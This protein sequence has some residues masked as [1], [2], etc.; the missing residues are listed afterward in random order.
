[1]WAYRDAAPQPSAQEGRMMS[2]KAQPKILIGPVSTDREIAE[3][4][5][6]L[7]PCYER[8]HWRWWDEGR[9]GK[10][11]DA[12]WILREL[13]GLVSRV[14]TERN[15]IACGGLEVRIE[16]GAKMLYVDAKLAP[17]KAA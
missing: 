14:S 2:R 13:T 3:Y 8:E 10:I 4:A 1:V 9:R 15:R 12:V 11:P 5:V 17:R 16:N 7:E 6:L